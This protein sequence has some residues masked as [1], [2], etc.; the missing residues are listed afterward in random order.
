MAIPDPINTS[1]AV[2]GATVQSLVRA[3]DGIYRLNVADANGNDVPVELVLRPSPVGSRRTISGTLRFNPGIYDDTFTTK[4]GS[5]SASFTLSGQIGSAIDTADMLA[6][7]QHLASIMCQSAVVTAL[8]V[9][10]FV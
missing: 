9:G 3:S 6:H 7:A 2:V 1:V 8:I 10:S 4:Q 5:L